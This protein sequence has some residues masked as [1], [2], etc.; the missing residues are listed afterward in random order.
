M[1]KMRSDEVRKA[2][3]AERLVPLWESP[4]AHKPPVPPRPAHLWKWEKVRPL[5]DLAFAETSPAAIERRVLQYM[6][7]TAKLPDEEYTVGSIQAAI[8]GLLPGETARPHRHTMNAIRF[9]LEGSKETTTTVDGKDCAMEVGDLVLTPAW[10]WHGHRHEGK[11]PSLWLDVLDVPLHNKLGT[12]KFQPPPM[13]D[14]PRTMNDNAYSVPNILPVENYTERNYTPIF[15]YPYADVVNA[16][17]YSPE[18]NDGSRRVRYVNPRTGGPAMAL[19][20]CQMMTVEKGRT[21]R[22]RRS[23]ANMFCMVIEGE[24]E[25]TI[26]EQTISWGPKDAFTIPQKNWTSHTARTSNVRVLTI[27]DSD[28]WARLGVLEEETQGVNE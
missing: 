22:P 23:N 26:G 5:L 24:G 17:N 28:A 21:T 7:P 4:T 6:C 13:V 1:S 9:I 16:L 14:V 18:S 20:D 11:A 15:R 19:L 2:W 27:S 3:L 12:V 10:T 8:Q 25:S